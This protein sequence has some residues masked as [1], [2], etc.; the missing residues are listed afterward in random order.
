MLFIFNYLPRQVGIETYLFKL[1]FAVKCYFKSKILQ[2]TFLYDLRRFKLEECKR[3]LSWAS[4]GYLDNLRYI[5]A[6]Y[7]IFY[8]MKD[9]E[10]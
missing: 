10:E 3:H 9:K 2:D 7:C 6:Y 4:S 5:L 1:S 8:C